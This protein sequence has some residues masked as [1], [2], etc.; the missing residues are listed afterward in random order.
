MSNKNRN[1]SEESL[2]KASG[3]VGMIIEGWEKDSEGK[4]HPA[5]MVLQDKTD[6]EHEPTRYGIFQDKE[7]AVRAAEQAGVGTKITHLP[8]TFN[9]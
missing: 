5:Y 8:I 1:M 7:S 4:E 2:G 9:K 3:G 6:G